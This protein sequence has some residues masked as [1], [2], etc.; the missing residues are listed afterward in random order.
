M[1]WAEYC[2]DLKATHRVYDVRIDHGRLTHT[3]PSYG[4]G[5]STNRLYATPG[6][7]LAA[8]TRPARKMMAIYQVRQST[9]D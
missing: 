8:H 7:D 5:K 2:P 1:I 9:D 6:P 3:R 4:G